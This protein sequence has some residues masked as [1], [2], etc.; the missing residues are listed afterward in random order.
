MK[1]FQRHHL[2]ILIAIVLALLLWSLP[3]GVGGEVYHSRE[4]ALRLAFPRADDVVKRQIFLDA[5]QKADVERRA[6]VELPSRLITVYVGLREQRIV[7]YAFIET[8]QVRSLPETLLIVIDPDGRA[9]GVHLLAF[10]EPPEYAPTGQWLAQFEGRRLGD[11]LSLR[12]DV[13]GITGATLT[14]NSI[15]AS[16]RRMLAVFEVAVGESNGKG[17]GSAV[18]SDPA[19]AKTDE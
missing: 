4:S 18:E 13:D 9:R 17:S 16:V 11:R 2:S 12:G 1:R 10:H 15:T 14:A 3:A 8:H 7:G 6:R 5:E 19:A